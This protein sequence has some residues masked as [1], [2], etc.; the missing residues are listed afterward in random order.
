MFEKD[1]GTDLFSFERTPRASSA[2]F[3]TQQYFPYESV[4]KDFD[5]LQKVVR[6]GGPLRWVMWG[7]EVSMAVV[8]MYGFHLAKGSKPIIV[9]CWGAAGVAEL[10]YQSIGKNRFL[11][12]KCPRCHNEWP[13]G[14]TE[15]DRRCKG[16]GLRL[17][18]FSP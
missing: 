14:K 17:H 12:W 8:G 11:H 2:P 15:K 18:Q 10:F 16:C 13:G 5:K 1:S 7:F 6:G 4:W 9:I 3:A